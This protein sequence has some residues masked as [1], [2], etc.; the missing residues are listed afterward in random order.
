MLTSHHWPSGARFLTEV[1]AFIDAT[2]ALPPCPHLHTINAMVRFHP[3]VQGT[4][5][6]ALE[7]TVSI[8]HSL[9]T[10]SAHHALALSQEA[11]RLAAQGHVFLQEAMALPGLAAYART[12]FISATIYAQSM[13]NGEGRGKIMLEGPNARQTARREDAKNTH[14][15]AVGGISQRSFKAGAQFLLDAI[16]ALCTHGA[17]VEAPVW[18]AFTVA[19][20]GLFRQAVCPPFH[21][22]SK[23]D[24]RVL[25]PILAWDWTKTRSTVFQQAATQPHGTLTP[26]TFPA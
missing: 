8:N 23:D 12:P 13:G 25:A 4:L 9:R 17:N 14:N 24:A 20:P 19:K 26:L 7:S 18:H 6:H 5:V 3:K 1:N 16:D 11:K 2:Q 10:I 15:V 21:A 22:A